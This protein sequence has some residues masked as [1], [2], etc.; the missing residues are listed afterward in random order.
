MARPSKDYKPR[1]E[2]D[3]AVSQ[4]RLSRMKSGLEAK[5][6]TKRQVREALGAIAGGAKVS[7]ARKAL[8]VVTR[9]DAAKARKQA[10]QD[11]RIAARNAKRQDEREARRAALQAER[12][13][14]RRAARNAT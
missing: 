6:Y 10:R 4:Q 11:A 9:S 7:E 5:G 12:Q 8:R 14:A 2:D 13:A 3:V 1:P